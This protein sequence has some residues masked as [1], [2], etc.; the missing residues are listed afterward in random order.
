[1]ALTAY[2]DARDTS[3]S[4]CTPGGAR[5]ASDC[6]LCCRWR[7]RAVLSPGQ[8]Q[9][10]ISLVRYSSR[11]Q[12]KKENSTSSFLHPMSSAN[13]RCLGTRPCFPAYAREGRIF[14]SRISIPPIIYRISMQRWVVQPSPL[15]SNM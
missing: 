2:I 8:L 4:K 9:L 3:I 15:K 6:N 1:M 12:S 14:N 5:H 10:A 11:Q 7:K 13:L